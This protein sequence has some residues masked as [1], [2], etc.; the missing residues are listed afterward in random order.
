[1]DRVKNLVKLHGGEY[2]AMENMELI[3][4]GSQ[5]VDAINGGIMTYGDGTLDRPVA[6]VQ[7]N[8][9][10]LVQWAKS[11]GVEFGSLQVR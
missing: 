2:I 6:L 7:V 1:M 3:Y 8:E 4:G 5:Y 11:Y 10:N 9:I